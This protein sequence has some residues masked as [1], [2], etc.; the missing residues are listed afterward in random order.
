MG[1]F[2]D[3]VNIDEKNLSVIQFTL[4]LRLLSSTV[5][6]LRDM[7]FHFG[8][9]NKSADITA[10]CESMPWLRAYELGCWGRS[11]EWSSW[12]KQNLVTL[13][14]KSWNLH[15]PRMQHPNCSGSNTTSFSG[16]KS[17]NSIGKKCWQRNRYFDGA[18]ENWQRSSK[19]CWHHARLSGRT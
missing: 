5:L 4:I 10:N 9:N 14:D 2:T 16:G 3:L 8:W 6:P 19:V 12:R 18:K 1:S 7:I 17:I 11:F 13:I 15:Y